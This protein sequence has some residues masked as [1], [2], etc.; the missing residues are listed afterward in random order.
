[1]LVAATAPRRRWT[2]HWR[3]EPSTV[4]MFPVQVTYCLSLSGSR[5]RKQEASGARDPPL[6]IPK[7][8][9]DVPPATNSNAKLKT[10]RSQKPESSKKMKLEDGKGDG[11]RVKLKVSKPR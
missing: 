3:R 1:M 11:M 9:Y 4:Q 7:K 10:K 2:V 8:E 5:K 6:K